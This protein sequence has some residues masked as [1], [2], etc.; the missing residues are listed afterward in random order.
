MTSLY[1]PHIHR[2]DIIHLQGAP[3]KAISFDEYIEAGRAAIC[4]DDVRRLAGFRTQLDAKLECD[5]A[6]QHRDLHE[7]VEVIFRFLTSPTALEASDPL[8]A[9]LAEAVVAL[10]YVL[11]GIDL[12]PDTVPEIGMTD[13]ARLV[14]RV[15]ARNPTISL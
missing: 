15:L 5:Q 10:N 8:P 11:K 9:D 4:A 12:I 14:A 2:A 7:G 1:R 3:G 6:R 13:D